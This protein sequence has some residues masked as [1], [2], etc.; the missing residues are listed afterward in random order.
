VPLIVQ[1]LS[2]RCTKD[3]RCPAICLLDD[4]DIVGV[5]YL[6]DGLIYDQL[7]DMGVQPGPGEFAFRIPGEVFLSAA[8]SALRPQT[9]TNRGA[10]EA[11]R[12]AVAQAAG[13][14]DRALRAFFD[15]LRALLAQWRSQH[16]AVP[17]P[18]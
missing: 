5:A 8:E 1:Q 3:E 16:R 17:R 13:S 7:R 2:A 18:A 6:A 10:V 11:Y 12:L 4:G 14:V 15:S 9:R